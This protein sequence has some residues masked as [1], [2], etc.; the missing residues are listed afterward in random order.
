[1]LKFLTLLLISDFYHQYKSCFTICGKNNNHSLTNSSFSLKLS[2][3]AFQARLCLLS[4][5][6]NTDEQ[7]LFY[8]LIMILERNKLTRLNKLT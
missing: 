7:F 3:D 1:M 5:P 6:V 4:S 2:D 8:N